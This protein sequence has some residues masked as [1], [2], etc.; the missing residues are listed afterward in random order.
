MARNAVFLL[1]L[2]N[3]RSAIQ[4]PDFPNIPTLHL[5]CLEGCTN[6]Y[7]VIRISC[8]IAATRAENGQRACANVQTQK[9]I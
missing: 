2:K 1:R 4:I 8:A 7:G 3:Y 5:S 9:K 6:R